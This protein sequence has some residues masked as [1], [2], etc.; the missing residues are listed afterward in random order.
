MLCELRFYIP[1]TISEAPA[2]VPTPNQPN[3][4]EK[5]N[6]EMEVEAQTQAELFN[7]EIFN[8]AH[9]GQFSSECIATFPEIPLVV[10]RGRYAADLFKDCIRFHGNTF[11]YRIEF[12]S[13]DKAFLLP[14]P[15]DVHMIFILALKSP[16]RQGNTNYPYIVMQ[17]KK[18]AE[19]VIKIKLKPE[20]IKEY[21]GENLKEEYSGPTFDLV[22]KLFK[23]IVGVNIIIP[24]NFKR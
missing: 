16:I 9:M 20:Q 6:S 19:E 18:D 7:Q 5:E 11:N 23:I 3:S 1:P 8:K 15:D 22:S 2:P 4:A 17:F 24:G 21:Y 10:P 14:K 13:I 12:K